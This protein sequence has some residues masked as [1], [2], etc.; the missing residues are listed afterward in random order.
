L[1]DAELQL[2][3]DSKGWTTLS[4]AFELAQSLRESATAC[5]VIGAGCSSTLAWLLGLSPVDPLK[6]GTDRRRF[7]VTSTGRA[8]FVMRHDDTTG[9]KPTSTEALYVSPMTP[10]QA[11]VARLAKE[12]PEAPIDAPDRAT[13]KFLPTG[14]P[15]SQ[16]SI[17]PINDL[18]SMI[19]PKRI[20]ELA[21]IIA[22]NQIRSVFPEHLDDFLDQE[23]PSLSGTGR[24]D[25]LHCPVLFQETVIDLLTR[26]TDL[27]YLDSYRLL[28]RAAR[29][30]AGQ[31]ELLR[32][33][34]AEQLSSR[35]RNPHVARS[36]AATILKASRVALCRAHCIGEAITIYRAAYFR[37]HFESEF[38]ATLKQVA[39]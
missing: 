11:V 13:F 10:M 27:P 17:P 32:D 6:Y 7:W 16:F 1:F 14:Q 24:E 21:E 8:T 34:L 35:L 19:R 22:I 18:V 39:A 37:T 33:E 15:D 9:A 3:E 20:T 29:A 2:I 12:F 5:Q 31:A 38:N 4:A 28:Q 30:T 23:R 36:F 25:R 26:W